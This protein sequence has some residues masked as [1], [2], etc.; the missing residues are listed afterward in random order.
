MS[1]GAGDSK[2]ANMNN[3]ARTSA[4]AS[5]DSRSRLSWCWYMASCHWHPS[6]VEHEPAK[7]VTADTADAALALPSTSRTE[8]AGIWMVTRPTPAGVTEITYS[9]TLTLVTAVTEPPTPPS[10]TAAAV[11]PP[12]C[13]AKLHQNP[14]SAVV[15][16]LQWTLRSAPHPLRE[17]TFPFN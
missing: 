6:C 7:Y 10:A 14:K 17:L 16:S 1:E 3:C 11:N 15:A 13:R 4:V 9:V 2:Q 8:S 12:T 5:T